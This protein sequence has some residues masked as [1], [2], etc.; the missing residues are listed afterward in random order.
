GGEARA[1]MASAVERSWLPSERL[2][3]GEEL[4][5][6]PTR[7]QVEARSRTY[8]VD[9][10]IEETPVAITDRRAAAEI[11]AREARL[12]LDRYLPAAESAA[13]SFLARVRWLADSFPELELPKLDG[14]ELAA[15]LPDV[16]LGLRSLDEIP[17]A[18]W[19][20]QL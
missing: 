11:L 4:F 14:E 8:W 1:R 18:D 5:Y 9:L 3:T 16:C 17:R 2:T 19:L 15:M 7:G 12:Q 6:N 10:L 20:S 13:G